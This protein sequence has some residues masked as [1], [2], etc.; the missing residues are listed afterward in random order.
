MT[1]CVGSMEMVKGSI[2]A[3]RVSMFTPGMAPK[4][5]PPNKP[6]TN[7]KRASKSPKSIQVP[8]MKCSMTL[9]SLSWQQQ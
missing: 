2:T 7:M 1:A 9:T 8:V 3:P 5:I 4:N 6:S